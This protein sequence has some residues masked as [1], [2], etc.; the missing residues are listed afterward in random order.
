MRISNQENVETEEFS[1]EDTLNI[2]VI[3]ETPSSFDESPSIGIAIL[4]QDKH[5]VYGVSTDMEGIEPI[6][7]D[8]N[9]FKALC[10]FSSLQLVPG[11]YIIRVHTLDHPGLRIFDMIEKKIWIKGETRE[12]GLYRLP[13]R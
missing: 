4:S 6:K 2:E 10:Q 7:I 5:P 8:K 11:K 13:H 3:V 12:G 1:Q 9:L